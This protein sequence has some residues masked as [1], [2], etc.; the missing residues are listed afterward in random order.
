MNAIRSEAG[1]LPDLGIVRAHASW[2][3]DQRTLP[4][5]QTV[6]RFDADFRMYLKLLVQRTEGCV[7]VLP[8]DDVPARVAEVALGEARRRLDEAERPGL[9][10]ET[11]RVKRLARGVMALCDHYEALSPLAVCALCDELI[12]SGDAWLEHTST[13]GGTKREGRIHRGC[14]KPRRRL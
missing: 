12:E 13:V 7:R 6:R 9:D 10:G 4:R 2:F 8:A 14:S 3:I 5:H 11:E 1:A